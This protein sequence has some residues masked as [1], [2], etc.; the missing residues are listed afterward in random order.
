MSEKNWLLSRKH[1]P[2]LQQLFE[3][4]EE[5]IVQRE[6]KNHAKIDIKILKG[7]RADVCRQ[8]SGEG[9]VEGEKN[10]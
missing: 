8:C 5:I 6:K 2:L 1:P 3:F 9:E 4:R 10:L 7:S